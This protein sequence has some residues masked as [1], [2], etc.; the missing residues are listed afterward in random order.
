MMAYSFLTKVR[1]VIPND[2]EESHKI[3]N[4]INEMLPT[5]A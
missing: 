3:N 5:S 2:S 4:F 1:F